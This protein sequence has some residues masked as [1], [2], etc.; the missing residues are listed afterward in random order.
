[1]WGSFVGTRHLP[2]R[3]SW[4]RSLRQPQR[5][6]QHS[7]HSQRRTRQSR[8]DWRSRGFKAVQSLSGNERKSDNKIQGFLD[9]NRNWLVVFMFF[10]PRID[11]IYICV[12]VLNK[13]TY[14]TLHYITL[15]YIHMWW[16]SPKTSICL[17][18]VETIRHA[19]LDD[20]CSGRC[21][22]VTRQEKRIK[23]S[24]KEGISCINIHL[25]QMFYV[26]TYVKKGYNNTDSIP[27]PDVCWMVG[28]TNETNWNTFHII[29]AVKYSS[30]T[31]SHAVQHHPDAPVT[32]LHFWM[33]AYLVL[34]M[35]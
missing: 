13:H 35:F 10:P 34:L 20:P 29:A 3:R 23:T 26:Y 2:R 14:I 8:N 30:W 6:S 4:H 28:N 32:I 9:D 19:H 27:V 21:D 12:C 31:F 25:G 33:V 24:Q 1:M 15:H 18:W 7:Q 22:G 16:W 11:T 17:E 5:H